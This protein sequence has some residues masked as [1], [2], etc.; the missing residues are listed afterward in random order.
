MRFTF[1]GIFEKHGQFPFRH[2]MKR[3]GAKLPSMSFIL[4]S[5]NDD[6]SRLVFAA[7]FHMFPEQIIKLT[8]ARTPANRPSAM[9]ARHFGW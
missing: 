4:G 2:G 3:N 6:L 8:A 5:H 7:P 1:A 9:I